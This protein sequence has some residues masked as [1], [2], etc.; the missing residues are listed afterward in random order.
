KVVHHKAARLVLEHPVHTG[1]G[2]H[3]SMPAH[4]LVH[5]HGVQTRCIEPSEPHVPDYDQP[6]GV[7]RFTEALCERL[8]AWLVANVGLPVRRIRCR[9][10]HDHLD[11]TVVVI[12]V[13]P[14]GTQ[15][16]DFVVQVHTDAA[17]HADNHGLPVH[18]VQS[19]LE[20]LHDVTCNYLK[21]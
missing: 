18:D 17:T 8:T 13:I 10:R 12:L 4:G 2:L 16:H 21:A 19:L 15:L 3:E 5:V 20:V 1:D 11:H 7:V 14:V 6:E 9:A